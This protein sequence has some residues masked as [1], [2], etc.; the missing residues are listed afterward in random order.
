MSAAVV[1]SDDSGGTL[2]AVRPPLLD[3]EPELAGIT[4]VRAFRTV[5]LAAGLFTK[6]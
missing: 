2:S 5:V 1:V 6:I 4:K 3:A